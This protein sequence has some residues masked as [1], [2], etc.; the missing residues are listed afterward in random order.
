MA[1]P[2]SRLPY[3]LLQRHVPVLGRRRQRAADV[4]A[5]CADGAAVVET[6]FVAFDAALHGALPAGGSRATRTAAVDVRECGAT[7]P[8]ICG[9]GGQ[10]CGTLAK[11]FDRAVASARE[12]DVILLSPGCASW[13]Q[14]TDFEARGRTFR[15]LVERLD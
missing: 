10:P 7:E 6:S 11:A 15:E 2:T 12:G 8:A 14:F 1:P 13:D 4:L 5:A 9:H 3:P